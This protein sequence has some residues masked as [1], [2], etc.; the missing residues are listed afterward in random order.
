MSLANICAHG[1]HWCFRCALYVTAEDYNGGLRCQR[2]QSIRLR[3]DPPIPGFTTD[4]PND[5]DPENCH[6]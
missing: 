5:T 3:F 2:C 1:G 6:V 4:E